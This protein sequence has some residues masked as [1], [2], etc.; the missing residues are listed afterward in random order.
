MELQIADKLYL[1]SRRDI[2]DA[3]HLYR[4]CLNAR[5]GGVSEPLHRSGCW[6]GKPSA[7]SRT[8]SRISSLALG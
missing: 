5:K 2:E 3:V 8:L 1:R 4:P 6:S 7:V